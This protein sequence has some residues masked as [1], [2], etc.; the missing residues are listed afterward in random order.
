MFRDL[1]NYLRRSAPGQDLA[2]YC[3]ITAII[4]LVGVGVFYRVSGGI[5]NLWGS[6]NSAIVVANPN[7]AATGGAAVSAPVDHQ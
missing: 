2:E 6:A 1:M 5:Q 7:A 4:A 3:L